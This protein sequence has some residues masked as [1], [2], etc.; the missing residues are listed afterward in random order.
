MER[1]I[2]TDGTAIAY[3][4]FGTGPPLILVHGIASDHSRWDPLVEH[5]NEHFTVYAMDRRGRGQSGDGDEYAIELES[6][7]IAAL[8]RTVEG[9]VNLYGHSSGAL[10][11]LEAAP[12][13]PNLRRLILY[14]PAIANGKE[15]TPSELVDRIQQLIDDDKP[16]AA[17][18]TFMREVLQMSTDG[19]EHYRSLSSWPARIAAAPTFPREMKTT[20]AYRLNPE[21]FSDL[22]TPT[23]LLAGSDSPPLFTEAVEKVHTALPNSRIHVLPNQQHSA[24]LMAPE[25]VA[26]IVTEFLKSE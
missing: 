24:D 1:V 25:M 14:E 9:P 2:S 23:L 26:S 7:D 19:I 4:R 3:K 15:I 8:A 20:N 12:L 6:Q 16:E 22:H 11:S 21:R 18:V 5:L 10:Y 17:L 13:I